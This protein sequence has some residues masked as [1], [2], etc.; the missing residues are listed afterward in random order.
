MNNKISEY[1]D[2]EPLAKLDKLI[3]LDLSECPICTKEDYRAKVFEMFSQLDILDN[4][5]ADGQSIEYGEFEEFAYGDEEFGE[6]EEG[7]LFEEEQDLGDEEQSDDE[8]EKPQKK[9]KQ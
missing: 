7:E 2:L 4:K 3:Q 9:L 5:D 6:E 8:E 1:A